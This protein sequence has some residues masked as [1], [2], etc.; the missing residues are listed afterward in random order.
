MGQHTGGTRRPAMLPTRWAA[1]GLHG[2]V[3]ARG[4]ALLAREVDLEVVDALWQAVRGVSDL[5]DFVAAL[6][7]ACGRGLL[8]LPDFAVA[9]VGRDDKVQVAARGQVLAFVLT[10][11]GDETV[12]GLGVDTWSERHVSDARAVVLQQPESVPGAVERSIESGVVPASSLAFALNASGESGPGQV[13]EEARRVPV[14]ETGH[15]P[16]HSQQMRAPAAPQATGGWAV[17]GGEPRLDPGRTPSGAPERPVESEATLPPELLPQRSVLE[18]AADTDQQVGPDTLDPVLAA[19]APPAPPAQHQVG[20]SVNA[21]LCP[22]G[23]ANPPHRPT[24]RI[25]R[26]PLVGATVRI[27]RPS[28]GR[29]FTPL[30]EAVELDGPV[31]VGRAPRAARFQGSEVPKLLT[32]AHTH[33]SANHL[34]LRPDGWHLLVQDLGSTNGTY[35]RRSAEAPVRIAEEPQLLV[36]GD[37]IDL[38]HGVHLRFEDL[39]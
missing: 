30:G 17:T 22:T 24:C 23:H 13:R 11:N 28:L 2:L 19:P 32:L 5:G 18:G 29:M 6:S 3:W 16:L 33:I 7:G 10:G 31:I 27:A 20:E 38:G 21:V 35:L 9:V 26:A 4:A 37:V 12:S 8:E 14:I 25:C 34:A 39:P 1:G 15:S 36:P